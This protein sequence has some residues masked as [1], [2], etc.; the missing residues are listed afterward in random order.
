MQYYY[1]DHLN[2]GNISNEKLTI[3][4]DLLNLAW[5]LYANNSTREF[6]DRAEFCMS[7]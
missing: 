2:S 7:F 1:Y 3:Y 4:K 5:N 6:M